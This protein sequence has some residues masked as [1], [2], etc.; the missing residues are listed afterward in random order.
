MPTYYFTSEFGG[1]ELRERLE[2]FG[3]P[4]NEWNKIVFA[5]RSRDF[6]DVIDPDGLN[7]IDYLEVGD[8]GEFFKMGIQIKRIYEK[9]RQGVAIIGLQKKSGTD[10]AY[11]GEMTAEKPRLYVT[12]ENHTLRIKKAKLWKGDRNPN[13]MSRRFKLFKGANFIWEPWEYPTM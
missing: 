4:M 5:E 1:D 11:G 9:L 2:P 13:G 3:H 7:I 12:L 6:Q 10:F 8:G